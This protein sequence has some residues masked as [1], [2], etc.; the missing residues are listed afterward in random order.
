MGTTVRITALGLAATLALGIPAAGAASS[1]DDETFEFPK[2]TRWKYVGTTNGTKTTVVQEVFKVSHG[3]LFVPGESITV[4]HLIM[5]SGSEGFEG[6]LESVS[7]TGFVAVD[8]EYFMTGSLGSAPV[9]L[10]KL[11]SKPGDSWPCTDPR[12]KSLPDRTF[13]HRGLEKVTVPAGVF[14]NARHVQVQVRKEGVTSTGDFYIVPGV[15]IVKTQA[16]VEA[17][18]GTRRVELELESFSPPGEF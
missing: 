16:V 7:T 18:G 12:L 6:G 11:G 14:R 17:S 1:G 2:G 5:R 4:Y 8:G 9:R 10:Y 3:E 13:T 15:G